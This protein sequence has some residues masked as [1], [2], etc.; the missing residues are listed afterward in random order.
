MP[1]KKD[2]I[3][4]LSTGQTAKLL[5]VTPDTILKWIKS[6]R[7][8]AVRTVGGHYRVAEEVVAHFLTGQNPSIKIKNSDE[9]SEPFRYCW[10]YFSK[11]SQAN[12][13]CRS[14]VVYLSHAIKCYEL[15]KIPGE[16]GYQGTF[17]ETSCDECSFYLEQH[18]RPVK[19]LIATDNASLEKSFL[20][21]AIDT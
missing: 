3:K 14:C 15:S 13:E 16:Y 8:T 5:S 6:G 12:K 1:I 20:S 7:I 18:L 9:E 10:D 19:V 2:N 21:A 11:D 17:C 4:Y